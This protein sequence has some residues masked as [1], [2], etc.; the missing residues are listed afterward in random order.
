[1]IRLFE[2]PVKN[3]KHDARMEEIPIIHT[4]QA[5]QLKLEEAGFKDSSF[6]Y[7][8]NDKGKLT[9]NLISKLDYKK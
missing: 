2:R 8:R 5:L 9:G 3:A 7:E 1:M 6:V 4:L